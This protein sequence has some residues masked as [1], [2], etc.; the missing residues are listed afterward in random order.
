MAQSFDG[1]F[2]LVEVTTDEL[3]RG[4]PK[5]QV[6]VVAA[7]PEQAIPLILAELPEGWSVVLSDAQLKP[8]EEALLKMQPG[9]VRELR[10]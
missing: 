1:H 7:K 10:G 4:I 2:Q 5:K 3:V 6:W 8:E 9:E